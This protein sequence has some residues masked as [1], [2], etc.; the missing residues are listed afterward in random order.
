M[1]LRESISPFEGKA[2]AVAVLAI[3]MLGAPA[4]K[5]A[6]APDLSQFRPSGFNVPSTPSAGQFLRTR[7]DDDDVAPIV[8]LWK[9]T[10][11]AK[12]NQAIPDGALID[13]GY[14]QW[15]SDGTEIM[16]SNRDP[17]T[18][19]FCLGVWKQVGRNSYALNHF[20]L[21]WIASSWKDPSAP[22]AAAPLGPVRIEMTVTVS[23]FNDT[24]KGKFTLTQYG[25]DETTV[26]PPTPI[27]GVVTGKRVRLDS[28]ASL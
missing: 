28:P 18:S 24:Y 7:Q 8:G 17:A 12:G 3:A 2:R 23:P 27:S 22:V 20:A 25:T 10:M 13:E 4:V 1:T 14:V 6:C 26:L 5:A 19:N 15:H 11:T 21:P 9:V 16:N